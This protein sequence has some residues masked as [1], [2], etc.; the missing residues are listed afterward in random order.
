MEFSN[1]V[2]LYSKYSPNSKK[3]LDMLQNSKIDLRVLSI[4]LVCIDNENI[5]KRIISCSS[6]EIKTV[7]SVLVLY[8]DGGVEKFDGSHSFQFIENIIQNYI[9]LNT[10]EQPPQ[11][12]PQ[13]SPQQPPPQQSPPQ[14]SPPQQSPPQ[15]S[16]KSQ[17]KRP[18]QIKRQTRPNKSTQNKTSIDDLFDQ[19]EEG[20][21]EPNIEEGDD[22][23]NEQIDDGVE[24]IESNKIPEEYSRSVKSKD[25]SSVLLKAQQL[26]KAREK[27][28]ANK[29]RRP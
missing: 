28:D 13:Q 15:Q 24:V 19:D 6:V 23:P 16:Q 11:P 3:M 20:F 7:P 9:K 18:S 12:P 29:P 25:T 8:P 14:Q 5:R 22:E 10:P 26:A 21:E 27:E 4:Q 1:I 17:Q 2:L